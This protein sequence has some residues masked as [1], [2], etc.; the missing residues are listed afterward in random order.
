MKLEIKYVLIAQNVCSK[1]MFRNYMCFSEL[2]VSFLVAKSKRHAQSVL[3]HC[4]T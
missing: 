4:C 1:I 3:N 2:A